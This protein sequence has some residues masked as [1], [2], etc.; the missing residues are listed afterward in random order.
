MSEEN[1]MYET[2]NDPLEASFAGADDIAELRA[3][4]ADLKAKLD[5]GT[6]AAAR[7]PL[8]GAAA[9]E[10]KQFVDRYLATATPPAS[11]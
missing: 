1:M 6:I 10:T 2:K 8:S 9:P 4:M 3:G 11:R 7:A 5:A